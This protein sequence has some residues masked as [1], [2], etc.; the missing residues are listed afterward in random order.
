MQ[1]IA[2]TIDTERDHGKKSYNDLRNKL[3]KLAEMLKREKVKATFFAT[4][5]CLKQAP[6]IFWKLNKEGHEIALHGYLHER[7]D[8]LDMDKKDELITKAIEVYKEV[9]AEK[10]S[11][12]RAPQFSADFGT[13]ET[14]ESKGFLYDSSI[15]QFPLSQMVFFPS[16]FKLYF[17]QCFF[18]L[19]RWMRKMKIKEI[20]VS[21]FGLPISM[22]M[23]KRLPGWLFKTLK[24]LS[25]IM[26]RDRLVVFLSHSYEF[27]E[28]GINR[29]RRFLREHRDAKFV[30]M[31]EIAR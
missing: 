30:T 17:E 15:V 31:M 5:D 1:K 20:P 28:K 2:I 22:Y 23:L 24:W 3:P 29:L 6:N 10:P 26:R 11:G 18:R 14:L 12:F 9:M 8:I 13:V 19:V 25:S 21:S 16:R 7:W 27:D 4:C